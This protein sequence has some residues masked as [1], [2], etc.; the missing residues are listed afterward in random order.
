[1]WIFGL[2]GLINMSTAIFGLLA[3]K[4]NAITDLIMIPH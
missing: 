4:L 1:M 2:K 3:A